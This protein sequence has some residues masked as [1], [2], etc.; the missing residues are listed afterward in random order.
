MRTKSLIICICSC[1]AFSV[2]GCN[3]QQK[4]TWKVHDK[5]RPLPA[6]ITPGQ[7]CG[8][9]PSDAIIL[10]DGSDLSKWQRDNGQEPA[11][12]VENGYMEVIKGTGSLQTKEP[13]GSC[14]LH[15]EWATPEVVS[16]KSQGRGN[17]GVFLMNKYEVQVLDSYENTTY[18]DGQAAAIY[19]QKPPIVNVCRPPGQWQ[20]YDIVFHQPVFKDKKVI[21]PAT[22]TVLQ[23]GVLVQDNWIIKGPT[24][25]K[26]AAVYVPH[27]DKLPLSLQNHG[28]PSRFRNIWIRELPE[29]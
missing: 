1:I 10:F 20:S 25:H 24:A 28:N 9:A 3:T 8:G 7:N 12:K 18:A 21:K 6:V 19:G 15:I 29:E 27:E 2:I 26:T 4:S 11:W 5:D 16:G 23:N 13:F 22:V 17:S 14:Q